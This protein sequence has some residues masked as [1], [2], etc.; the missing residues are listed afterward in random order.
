MIRKETLLKTDSLADKAVSDLIDKCYKYQNHPQDLLIC[1]QHGSVLEFNKIKSYIIGPADDG[2]SSFSHLNFINCMAK[3]FLTESTNP[4][5]YS[6]EEEKM[7]IEYSVHFEKLLYLKIW[8]NVYFIK[9]LTQLVRIA[10]G[11]NYD[12]ELKIPSFIRG[13]TKSDHIRNEIKD[14]ISNRSEMFYELVSGSYSQQIRN[15]IAH[16]QYYFI[17]NGIY[18]TNY[19]TDKYSKINANGFDDW[20]LR[21]SKTI[22]LFLNVIKYFEK[23]HFD[24]RD[25]TISNGNQIEV[26]VPNIK[27][28]H[29]IKLLSYF[30]VGK[31][32]V[33]INS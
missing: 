27:N 14:K 21:Y 30:E 29:D 19:N 23:I 17:Q 16:S 3:T 24:Y 11:K 31:R 32:W 33:F 2:L 10:R 25:K 6:N 9:Q 12:W 26:R 20:E 8:E 15:A 18:Y 1:Q 22:S 28:Q 4:F 7:L 5:V 13:N